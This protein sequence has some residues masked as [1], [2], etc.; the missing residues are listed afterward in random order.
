VVLIDQHAADERIGLERL[1]AQVGEPKRVGTGSKAPS[2]RGRQY[3]GMPAGGMAVLHGLPT[4][5]S[6][7]PAWTPPAVVPLAS[8][9][10]VPVQLNERE[11]T[12]LLAAEGRLRRWGLYC[13]VGRALNTGTTAWI[14][15]VRVVRYL[16]C[17]PAAACSHVCVP[18]TFCRCLRWWPTG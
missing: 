10:G 6:N 8:P 2:L 17:R 3:L 1:V 14:T 7:G 9:D 12:Q 15:H 13:V 18:K 5:A 11:R 4:A 16:P